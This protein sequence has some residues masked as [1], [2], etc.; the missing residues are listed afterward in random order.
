MCCSNW[1]IITADPL[2]ENQIKYGLLRDASE[3]E[4][5]VRVLCI[6]MCAL[7]ELVFVRAIEKEG[8]C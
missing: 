3:R 5:A 4:K 8:S 7:W 6:V 1:N 2:L